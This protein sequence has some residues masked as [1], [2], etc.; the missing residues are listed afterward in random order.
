MNNNKMYNYNISQNTGKLNE[1]D[2]NFNTNHTN[3][4]I[5]NHI[6]YSAKNSIKSINSRIHANST[7]FSNLISSDSNHSTNNEINITNNNFNNNNINFNNIN[8]N[9]NLNANFNIIPDNNFNNSNNN[10]YDNQSILSSSSTI[11]SFNSQ[12]SRSHS[13]KNITNSSSLNFSLKK[14]FPNSSNTENSL[15]HFNL[16]P[17]N[18]PAYNFHNNPNNNSHN[19]NASTISILSKSNKTYTSRSSSI[20]TIASINTNNNNNL[21][22]SDK[23]IITVEEPTKVITLLTLT[24]HEIKLIRSSWNQMLLDESS[25]EDYNHDFSAPPVTALASSLFCRQFY[26]NL[27]SMAPELEEMY[28]SIKHQAVAYSGVLSTAITHL[29]NLSLLDDYLI[30]LGRRHSRLL[31]IEPPHFELMGEAFLKTFQDR[32]GVCFTV[33]LEDLWSRLYSYLANTILQGG[34]DPLMKFPDDY[35]YQPDFDDHFAVS[36]IIEPTITNLSDANMTLFDTSLSSSPFSNY[37]VPLVSLSSTVSTLVSQSHVE[38][39]P[40]D[41]NPPRELKMLKS[42]DSL[43]TLNLDN[44]EDKFFNPKKSRLLSFKKRINGFLTTSNRQLYL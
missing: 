42:T 12:N 31:G 30:Q 17:D 13:N 37:T 43:E 6:H 16:S 25:D 44:Q 1:F 9:T 28:P 34:V 32:F 23:N 7:S 14:L 5:N 33:E 35:Y 27:L 29:E 41:I 11:K 3:N 19:L 20:N 10:D 22:F 24:P 8:F 39:I 36:S 40:K 26:H 2:N 15:K 4:Q 38:D 21:M 18:S